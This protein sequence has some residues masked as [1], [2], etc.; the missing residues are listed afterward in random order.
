MLT[1]VPM[2]RLSIRE[3][4]AV[5]TSETCMRRFFHFDRSFAKRTS[6]CVRSHV[7][8]SRSVRL[9]GG[10]LWVAALALV[11]TSALHGQNAVDGFDPNPDGAV[12]AIAQQT[13]GKLL[14]GGQFENV[15]GSNRLHIARLNFNGTVDGSFNAPA[16]AGVT[17]VAVQPDGKIIVAGE[18]TE[19]A[20]EP[21]GH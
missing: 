1:E 18:F 8:F 21:R 14:I 7:C 15:D 9:N 5:K 17:C 16:N 3:D 20:G 10:L 12:L 2:S 11:S 13:D 19:L 4:E 6:K